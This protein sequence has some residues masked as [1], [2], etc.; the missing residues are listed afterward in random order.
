MKKIVFQTLEEKRIVKENTKIKQEGTKMDKIS[1]KQNGFLQATHNVFKDL[2]N[3]AHFTNVTLVT[4]GNRNITAHKVI[5]SAFRLVFKDILIS[6]SQEKPIIYFRKV[7][8]DH[9][10]AIVNFIYLGETKDD[11]ECVTEFLELASDLQIVGLGVDQKQDQK[12]IE[13]MVP[14]PMDVIDSTVDDPEIS[15]ETVEEKFLVNHIQN[16]NETLKEFDVKKFSCT[17]CEYTT[18]KKFN[19]KE[20]NESVHEGFKYLCHLCEHQAST[21]N[22][23]RKHIVRIH[24]K[25]QLEIV[26]LSVHVTSTPNV[27]VQKK[28]KIFRPQSVHLMEN[29]R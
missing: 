26:D 3:D 18:K 7:K 13:Q 16:K 8:F 19:L 28:M 14:N 4:E 1:L 29:S 10:Q 25:I 12:D 5:L 2:L 11:L 20:H 15:N 27:K 23:L 21:R 22:N 6:Q 24:D 17:L 9:L